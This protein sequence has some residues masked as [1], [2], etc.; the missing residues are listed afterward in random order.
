MTDKP[1]SYEGGWCQFSHFKLYKQY[2][3]IVELGFDKS[4][5]V[6]TKK[7]HIGPLLAFKIKKNE[8]IHIM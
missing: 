4:Y 2:S 3:K 1:L 5:F 7:F 8:L 6:P